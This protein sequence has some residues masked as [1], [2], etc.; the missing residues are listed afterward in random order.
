MIHDTFQEN[1]CVATVGLGYETIP[2]GPNGHKLQFWD[3]AGQEA[4][5]AIVPAFMRNSSVIV[6]VFSVVDLASYHKVSMWIQLAKESSP[7]A[8]LILV[9]NKID[10]VDNS[11]DLIEDAAVEADYSK[12]TYVKT[13]A[14]SGKGTELLLEEIKFLADST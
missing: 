1:G 6:V 2:L 9:G 11:T 8:S 14:R 3:T 12:Y 13:S 4:Y 10:C 5:N 7:N